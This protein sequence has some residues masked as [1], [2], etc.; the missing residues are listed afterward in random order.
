MSVSFENPQTVACQALLS[1]GFFRQEDWS[2]LPRSSPGHLPDRHGILAPCSAG[3]FFTAEPPGKH[4]LLPVCVHGKSLSCVWLCATLSAVAPWAPLS[5]GFSRQEC[6]SGL[7]C[8]PPGDL[9]N[10]G[11]EPVSPALAGRFS[12]TS[13]TE[14]PYCCLCNNSKQ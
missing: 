7:P 2:G 11:I 14:C 12:T 8:P 4:V 10:P 1:M 5:R 13:P 6:W 9:P 3:R